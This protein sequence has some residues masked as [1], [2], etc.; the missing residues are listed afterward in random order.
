MQHAS[1]VVAQGIALA[2]AALRRQRSA[3]PADERRHLQFHAPHFAG[4]GGLHPAEQMEAVLHRPWQPCPAFGRGHG[5][6]LLRGRRRRPFAPVVHRRLARGVRAARLGQILD[7]A[8]GALHLREVRV[9]LLTL[10]G[11]RGLQPV[12][13]RLDHGL[14]APR[15]RLSQPAR[16]TPEKAASV[17][18]C[19]VR[20]G[21]QHAAVEGTAKG[22]ADERIGLF[23]LVQETVEIG[24]RR[25]G[26]GVEQAGFH[27]AH[28]QFRVFHNEA[29]PGRHGGAARFVRV[30][31]P[32]R[33]P[34]S[35]APQQ[36]HRDGADHQRRHQQQQPVQENAARGRGHGTILVEDWAQA[37]RSRG[38]QR[39]DCWFMVCALSAR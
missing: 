23:P 8:P 31:R 19:R 9:R 30:G 14:L 27:V 20:G 15:R 4:A 39:E 5:P 16:E 21:P 2:G 1:P 10:Q 17:L 37:I 18:V 25:R 6:S 13:R 12:G 34:R 32:L 7:I 22:R 35:L 11:R 26:Q 24:R 3:Q 29:G 33:Q 38:T 36:L 28:Q